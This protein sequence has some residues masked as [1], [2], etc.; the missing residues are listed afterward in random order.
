MENFDLR[1]KEEEKKLSDKSEKETSFTFK[2]VFWKICFG[3]NCILNLEKVLKRF[4]GGAGTGA[5]F[6][7]FQCFVTG[8]SEKLSL[9]LIS[10]TAKDKAMPWAGTEARPWAG[11]RVRAWAGV[12]QYLV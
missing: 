1:E 12:S 4:E 6:G 9:E 11:A 5:S 8:W 3:W 10:M 7:F 2:T